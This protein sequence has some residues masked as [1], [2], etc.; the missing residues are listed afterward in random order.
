VSA[1]D[2]FFGECEKAVMP[3][4]KKT[5]W[6]RVEEHLRPILDCFQEAA[7]YEPKGF[8]RQQ[9]IA[10]ARD[11]Y[12]VF[13]EDTRLLRL[14]IDEMRQKGLTIASPRSCI[15]V[16]TNMKNREPDPNYWRNLYRKLEAQDE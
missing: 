13:H 7:G 6:P 16:A 1:L 5:S 8:I 4:M 3:E 9:W 14:A 2:E 10:G 15:T 12:S 11:W